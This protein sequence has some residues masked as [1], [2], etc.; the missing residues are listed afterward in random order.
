MENEENKEDAVFWSP[1]SESYPILFYGPLNNYLDSIEFD[2]SLDDEA[3]TYSWENDLGE[4][5]GPYNTINEMVT[6]IIDNWE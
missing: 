6:D 3:G 1:N 4:T 5:G 2:M